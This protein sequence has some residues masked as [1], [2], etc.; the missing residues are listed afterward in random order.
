[1]IKT[2]LGSFGNNPQ[3]CW[4]L[5]TKDGRRNVRGDIITKIDKK[6][7]VV[8]S[9]MGSSMIPKGYIT[10]GFFSEGEISFSEPSCIDIKG[11]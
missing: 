6:Y 5:D 3:P 9:A 1:M 2:R 11:H 7:L 8:Y 10:K 4:I